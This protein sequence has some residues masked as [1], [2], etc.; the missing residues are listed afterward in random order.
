MQKMGWT[1]SLSLVLTKQLFQEKPRLRQRL[2]RRIEVRH[3][4]QHLLN[5]FQPALLDQDFNVLHENL[6]EL[7]GAIEHLACNEYAVACKDGRCM[8]K[9]VG[10]ERGS[11]CDE[12]PGLD[13]ALRLLDPSGRGNF[14]L[15]GKELGGPGQSSVEARIACTRRPLA[16]ERDLAGSRRPSEV[17]C[18]TEQ[19]AQSIAL[20]RSRD[21][22]GDLRRDLLQ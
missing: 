21:V 12:P 10:L 7:S 4:V 14:T 18:E 22:L 17:V 1:S 20:S 8:S 19:Q 15:A 9:R 2:A 5:A 6:F 16:Y 13:K 11:V 3:Q